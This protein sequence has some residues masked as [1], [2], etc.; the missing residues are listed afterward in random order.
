MP[1][2]KDREAAA[3]V[4]VAAG[5][6]GLKNE[7]GFSLLRQLACLLGAEIAATRGA[8]DE[9]WLSADQMV[10]MSGKTVRPD[11]YLAFGVSGTHYHTVGIKGRPY[12]IAVNTNPHARIFTMADQRIIADAQTVLERM[13]SCLNGVKDE[14]VC[15]EKK[16]LIRILIQAAGV[17]C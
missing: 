3:V 15:M 7:T 11:I 9:G 16:D 10:G 17:C 13:I 1:E 5:G 12:I 6:R 2:R 14:I 4:C 8:V